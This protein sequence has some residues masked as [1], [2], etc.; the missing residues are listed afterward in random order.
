MKT[1]LVPLDGSLTAEQVLPYAHALAATL[2]FDVELLQ[3]IDD[4]GEA[5]PLPETVV[6]AAASGATN[7]TSVER[8][9]PS[10]LAQ[11]KQ[12]HAYLA[13]QAQRFFHGMG[14]DVA[15]QVGWPAETIVNV[16]ER[17]E[18]AMIAMAT[19]G[20]SGLRRWTLGNITD[21]VVQASPVP[22]FV[23]R[24][25]ATPPA[26]EPVL[27]RVLVP[28][29]GSPLARQ[30]LP[31]A[32]ELARRAHGEL[33]LCT[34]VRTEGWGGPAFLPTPEEQASERAARSK[35]LLEEAA[36]FMAELQD[37]QVPVTPIV[38]FDTT[39][40]EA[41]IDA[42]EQHEA[43][44]VVMATHGYSGLRRWVLGSTADKLLHACPKPLLLV[45]TSTATGQADEE[46]A[47]HSFKH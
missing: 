6:I 19:H 22:T 27:R 33:V 12:A 46:A 44:L 36:P 39:V 31:I 7:P 41:I 17:H 32:C 21:K 1:M 45:R 16:A 10:S 26:H 37:Q 20:Y 29:D 9:S 5:P 18:V 30:A 4:E 24:A 15:V 23:V 3:V 34:V 35:Q 8:V 40:A 38:A 28:L 14:V 2:G 25:S 11:R 47:R 42:V 43:D 13:S